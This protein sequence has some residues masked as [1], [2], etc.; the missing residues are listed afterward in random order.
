MKREPKYHPHAFRYRLGHEP[1]LG[2]SCRDRLLVRI[3]LLLVLVTDIEL[4]VF[5]DC[6]N[7]PLKLVYQPRV[8]VGDRVAQVL[9]LS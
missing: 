7:L 4:A 6:R 9:C 1:A 3:R 5:L 2:Y 8:D